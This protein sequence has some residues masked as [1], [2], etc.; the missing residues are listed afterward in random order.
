MKRYKLSKRS[1][2]RQFLR[3]HGVRSM[4]NINPMRGG[5]RL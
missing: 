4:N 5:I 2:K 1:N 3:G